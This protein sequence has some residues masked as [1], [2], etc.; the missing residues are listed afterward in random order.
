MLALLTLYI[1]ICCIDATY[2]APITIKENGNDV[3]RYVVTAF[4]KSDV[5]VSGTTVKVKYNGNVQIAKTPNNTYSPNMF[6]EYRLS[7]KTVKFTA[8]LS[9]VGCSCDAAFYFVSM[10]GYGSNGNPTPGQ[11]GAL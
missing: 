10:P 2:V 4:S 5:E 6:Q 8:D 7:G 11:W 9:S 3:T 1:V